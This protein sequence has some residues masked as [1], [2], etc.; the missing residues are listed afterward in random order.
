VLLPQVQDHDLVF[1]LQRPMG[2]TLP[3]DLIAVPGIEAPHPA[4]DA[5]GADNGAGRQ[6]LQDKQVIFRPG[7]ADPRTERAQGVLDPVRQIGL[8]GRQGG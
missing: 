2:E 5:A 1:N 3:A 6:I 4:G 7:L 8:I